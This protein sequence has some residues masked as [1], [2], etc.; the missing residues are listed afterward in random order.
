MKGILLLIPLVLTL[1]VLC[2]QD[3][4]GSENIFVITIDGFRWQEIF[5]GADSHLISDPRF[6]MDTA[7]TRQLFWDSSAEMRRKK[8]MPFLWNIIASQ[9]QIYGNRLLGNKA[10]V[11]NWSR[12]SYPGYNEMLTGYTDPVCIPNIPVN[13][14]NISVLEFL[15]SKKAFAG[16][17]AAFSSWNLFPAILNEKRS[18]LPLNSGYQ[19]LPESME[20][21]ERGSINQVQG[22]VVQK[23]NTRSDMLTFLCAREY[24]QQHHPRVLFLGF[25]QNDEFAHAGRYDL[26]LEQ[27]AD[28]DRMVAELWYYVQT[29]PLYKGHTTFLI[30][31]DHGRGANPSTWH[32]HGLFT[33]GSSNTWIALLGP[34][35]LPVGEMTAVQHTYQKQIAATIA[36][37]LGETFQ[38]AHAIGKPMELPAALSEKKPAAPRAEVASK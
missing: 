13:N 18:R 26:Y 27:A 5:S 24:I 37:L 25:G 7:L 11:L 38:S 14:P 28:I 12:I 3:P 1:S 21:E 20:G 10:D 6:V 22:G 36:S 34:A 4:S 15:N 19:P 31:T 2:A 32:T 29:D 23:K 16:R 9:G 8:L 35:I 17:V 33:P 30:T